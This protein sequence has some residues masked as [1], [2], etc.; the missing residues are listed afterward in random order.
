VAPPSTKRAAPDPL[1]PGLGGH[2]TQRRITRR[3]GAALLA[4]AIIGAGVSG[5]T[6][7]Q[8]APG[9][10]PGQAPQFGPGL[11]QLRDRLG[12]AMG[13][14]LDCGRTRGQSGETTVQTTTGKATVRA[15]RG[16]V[17]FTDGRAHYTLADG[18][19]TRWQGDT[20]ELPALSQPEADYLSATGAH[21]E[22]LAKL[23]VSLQEYQRL[24]DAGQLEQADGNALLALRY[25]FSH[26]Q[27]AFN[28]ASPSGRFDRFIQAA[29]SAAQNG[30]DAA[31]LLLQAQHAGPN[32]D[33]DAPVNSAR[34]LVSAGARFQ[35]DADDQL[36]SIVPVDVDP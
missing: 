25:Q 11:S 18:R 28:G 29:R 16:T 4:L 22:R 14:P 1:S 7:A 13:A 10:A 6:L 31:N 32:D 30:R 19:L 21:R 36:S 15:D 2:P 23:Y 26:A 9:C 8:S 34:P 20:D 12:D 35:R 33:H 17:T 5:T 27:Q 3:A 24:A